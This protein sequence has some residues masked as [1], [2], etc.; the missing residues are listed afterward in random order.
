[1]YWFLTVCAYVCVCV[2]V[3]MQVVVYVG[4]FGYVGLYV[5]KNGWMDGWTGRTDGRTYVSM[6]GWM[7]GWMYRTYTLIRPFLCAAA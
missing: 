4:T 1:M 6:D 5:Y 2:C 3:R 7:D